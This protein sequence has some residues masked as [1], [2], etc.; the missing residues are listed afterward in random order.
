MT[1]FSV[2]IFTKSL[3][4]ASFGGSLLAGSLLIHAAP[5]L[6]QS[7]IPGYTTSGSSGGSTATNVPSSFGFY[8]DSLTTD[9]LNGLGFAS[10]PG[11]GNGTSYEVK[12]WKWT[13]GGA[14]PSDYTVVASTTFT[15]GQPYSFQ[16]GYFWQDVSPT[17]P[18]A[19]TFTNDPS[20]L[21]GYVITAYGDFSNTP[22]NV[23]FEVGTATFNPKFVVG[24]TGASGFNDATDPNGFYPVP[25]YPGSMSVGSN[26][27]FNAN[28]S[29]VPG[30]LP[31]LG[32]AA[33]FGWS[34]RLRKRIRRSK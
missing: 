33:G 4:F 32:A 34:R 11:W 13:N 17:I 5:A 15:H 31:V 29:T 23:E 22:G 27:Y 1:A 8:F 20:N 24:A 12:L 19:D 9:P 2:S 25:I 30:P 14:N 26:G 28:L 6:A 18:L 10:Q 7:Y 16:D 3:S 21:E